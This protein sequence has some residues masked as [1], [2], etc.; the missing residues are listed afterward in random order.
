MLL[1]CEK[2]I[3]LETSASARKTAVPCMPTARMAVETSS[4][5]SEKPRLPPKEKMPMLRALL[6]ASEA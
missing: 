5:P 6:F 2:N 4:G 3:V 1:Y